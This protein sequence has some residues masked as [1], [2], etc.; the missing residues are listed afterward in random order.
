MKEW[1]EKANTLLEVLPYI[2][3]FYN[4]TMVI[5]IGGEP[6]ID[7]EA[8][9][10]FALDLILMKYVG[11]N[12]IVVHGGGKQ[13]TQLMEKLGKKSIFIDGLRVTDKETI[14]ITEMVLTGIINKDIVSTINKYGGKAVGISGRD[15][16]LIEARKIKKRNKDLGY[17]GDIKKINPDIISTVA[18]AGFIPVISP[19]GGNSSGEA[20]NINADTVAGEI[21]I[22]LNATKL[23]ILSDVRGIYIEKQNKKV[24][25]STI[26]IKKVKELIDSGIIK[27]G[28]LPKVSACIRALKNGVEKTH[29]IDGKI[30]HSLL[31]E[32]FTEAGVGTEIVRN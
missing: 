8:K 2:E 14:E 26:K 29:I 28:M 5:K 12:P 3:Q 22:A 13:I 1:I 19:I 17:V 27:T 24:F 20:F 25:L 31:L 23:I 32:I 11:I 6:M 7:E 15:G 16:K 4:K 30:P 18:K 10:N 21:A 9:R